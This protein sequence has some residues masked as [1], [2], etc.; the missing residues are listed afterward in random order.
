MTR[1]K[2]AKALIEKRV[3]PRS[4]AGIEKNNDRREKWTCFGRLQ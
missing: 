1:W 4:G 2:P 3:I